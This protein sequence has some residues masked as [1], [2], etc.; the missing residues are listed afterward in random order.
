LEIY[1][2]SKAEI[3]SL[4]SIRGL[5][6]I[7]VVLLHFSAVLSW[8]LPESS[9]LSPFIE[10]GGFAVPLF[11]ILSG[12]VLGL[13]YLTNL[14]SLDPR[15]LLRFWILRLGRIYPVHLFTLAI[16][17]CLVARNR[18]PTDEGHS[19]GSFVANCFL[20][21]AWSYDLRLSWNYPSWSISSEWFAYLIFPLVAVVTGRAS[22]TMAAVLVIVACI[23]SA[24]VYSC[25]PDIK[26]R[27][28]AV[29]LPTFI[30]GVG[31]AIICPPGVLR[32]RLQPLAELGLVAVVTLPYAID[33]GTLRSALYIV[34]FFAIVA[35]L[36]VPIH[37]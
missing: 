1:R 19:L 23:M 12:Y 35:V 8:I 13:R 28:L 31:L 17:L 10:A 33:P 11:F 5:A 27:G 25:E 15:T 4:T 37:N 21:N 20:V 29:V 2:A 32:A 14:T 3:A 26:F 9:F 30:G 34:L 6:A 18:W 22:R 7:W 36:V 24:F 16:S